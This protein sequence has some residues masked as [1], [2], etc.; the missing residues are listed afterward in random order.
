MAFLVWIEVEPLPNTLGQFQWE[1]VNKETYRPNN[2]KKTAP[3][4]N[5]LGGR[6]EL[7]G[8]ACRALA[9]FL[10][11]RGHLFDT[12]SPLIPMADWEQRGSVRLQMENL[13]GASSSQPAHTLES[14]GSR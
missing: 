2:G 8:R 3:G 12:F 9:T 10:N 6:R 11:C 4:S 5:A 14:V 13:D 7:N 1:A